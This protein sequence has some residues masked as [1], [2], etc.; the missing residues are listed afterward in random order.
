MYQTTEAKDGK[1]IIV[2][3]FDAVD[4]AACISSFIQRA[5][6]DYAN[7]DTHISP[8]P[9]G[10]GAYRAEMRTVTEVHNG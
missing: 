3:H 6:P 4:T 10:S 2:L 7:H 1:E 8:V 9:D 5:F